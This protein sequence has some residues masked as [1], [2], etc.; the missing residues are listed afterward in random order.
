M[1]RK[2]ICHLYYHIVH[3]LVT[4]SDNTLF[5]S[6]SIEQTFDKYN[7]QNRLKICPSSLISFKQICNYVLIANYPG[8]FNLVNFKSNNFDH[9]GNLF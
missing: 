2:D 4:G 6:M 8:L 1:C 5:L 9:C 7:V 3:R